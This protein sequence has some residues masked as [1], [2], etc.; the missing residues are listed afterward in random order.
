MRT[1]L[2]TDAPEAASFLKGGGVVAFPTETVYGLGANIFDEASLGKIFAAKQRPVD[3]PLIAHIASID[4]LSHL[5]KNITYSAQAFFAVLFPGPLTVILPKAAGVPLV[6]TAGLE[7]IGVR[8]PRHPLAQEFL[9]ACGMP[10]AAPSANRSGRPSPTTYQTVV[11]DLDGRIDAI[12]CGEQTEVG[13]ESTIVDCTGGEPIVLRAGAVTLE[14]LRKVVPSTRLA[15]E[16]DRR[17][18]RSPG[19]HYRHYSP[20]AAVVLVTGPHDAKPGP[21]MAYIGVASPRPDAEFGLQYICASHDDYAHELFLFFRVCDEADV[22][23]IY[24]Q[25][26]PETGIGLALMDRLRRAAEED[27]APDN[28]L[29]E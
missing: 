27:L 15:I 23:V 5:V 4:Q 6:A 18:V 19:T 21:N 14:E 10:V 20:R 17:V 16:S 22:K 9:R 11:E 29:F 12:L 24:C 26:V 2:T 7:T 28:H 13:L 1:V 3:N 25:K 8:M